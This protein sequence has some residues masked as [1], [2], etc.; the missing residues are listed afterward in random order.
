MKRIELI[1]PSGVG[2]STLYNQICSVPVSERPFVSQR[3]AFVNAA[4]K[5]NITIA[6]FRLY[7]LQKIL[8]SGLLKPKEFGIA[9]TI[10][11][12]INDKEAIA[13]RSDYNEFKVSFQMYVALV[14][15]GNP[16][17]SHQRIK[18]FMSRLESFLFLEHYYPCNELILFDEGPLHHHCGFTKYGSDT[19]TAE[20]LNNDRIMNPE[21]LIYCEG[22]A[23][24]IFRQALKRKNEGIKTFNHGSLSN[25]ELKKSIERSINYNENKVDSFRQRNIPVLRIDTGEPSALNVKKIIEFSRTL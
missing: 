15:V 4:L 6:D 7:L 21:G 1:G 2:K 20:E 24:R 9:K 3:E 19:F 11:H 13:K 18:N 14:R 25:D 17:V 5:E 16:Y 12:S 22:T 23:E 8:K 10:I